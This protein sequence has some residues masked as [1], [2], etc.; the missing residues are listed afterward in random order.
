MEL[1]KYF[2]RVSLINCQHRPDRLAQFMENAAAAGITDADRIEIR[3]AIVGDYTGHPAGW[4]AG[5]GGWG[6]LQSHRRW[7]EDLM[8]DRDERGALAWRSALILEDDAVFSDDA[9]EIIESFVTMLPIKWGQA[10]LGGQHQEAPRPTTIPGVMQGRS[11]NRTHAYAIHA[12]FINK[13]YQHISYMADY[14]SCKHV[15]HQLELGHQREDWPV[16][17]PTRWAVGQEAGSSNI[18]GKTNPRTFFQS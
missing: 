18:S 11:I 17:C 7:M 6:C 8:H 4:G 15:D 1:F 16:F 13:V 14:H 10:Y 3:R 12:S 5:N 9:E 2:D